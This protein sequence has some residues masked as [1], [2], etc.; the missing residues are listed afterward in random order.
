MLT[1]PCLLI[2]FH[3]LQSFSPLPVRCL[4]GEIRARN[5]SLGDSPPQQFLQWPGSLQRV[6]LATGSSSKPGFSPWF[7][8]SVLALGGKKM[9]YLTSKQPRVSGFSACRSCSSEGTLG[10]RSEV[11]R[12][13]TNMHGGGEAGKLVVV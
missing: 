7:P 9:L 1:F 3:P 8:K 2:L 11:A 10:P 12:L 4:C 6:I 5:G 13:E